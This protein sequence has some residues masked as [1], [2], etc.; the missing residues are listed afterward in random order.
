MVMA[1]KPIFADYFSLRSQP[2]VNVGAKCKKLDK[3]VCI[4]LTKSIFYG[5]IF[6][7][8]ATYLT[9]DVK[10]K[11]FRVFVQYCM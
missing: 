11:E 9:I 2:A 4:K 10:L 6:S 1:N 8:V 5:I 3:I 7:S